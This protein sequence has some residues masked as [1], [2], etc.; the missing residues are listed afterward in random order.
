MANSLIVQNEV[1]RMTSNK[2]AKGFEEEPHKFEH[3]RSSVRAISSRAIGATIGEGGRLVIPAELRKLMEVAPGE[4]VSLQV[5]D[6]YLKVIS[7][8]MLMRKIKEIAAKV[9]K[10]GESVVDEFLADR[11]AEQRAVDE[12]FDRLER[13]A[14]E[15]VRAQKND[16]D[17]S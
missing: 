14:A 17:R 5:E 3:Q 4:T 7:K 12:R 15:I 2:R 9:K 11:R 10:P 6:G 13:E 1:F 16:K 8:T